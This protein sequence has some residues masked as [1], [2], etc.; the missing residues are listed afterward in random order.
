MTHQTVDQVRATLG[1]LFFEHLV[2]GFN[3]FRHL[4]MSIFAD[5]INDFRTGGK[6]QNR[7][8]MYCHIH[9]VCMRAR[10]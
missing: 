10:I 3:P 5:F 6:F 7:G 8:I 2:E 4:G 1:P 9:L